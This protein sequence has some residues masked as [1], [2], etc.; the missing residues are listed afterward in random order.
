MLAWARPTVSEN[1]GFFLRGYYKQVDPTG[2]RNDGVCGLVR[3]ICGW[4]AD[5]WGFGPPLSGLGI[6]C[7]WFPKAAPWAG[8][9]R[10]LWGWETEGQM[11]GSRM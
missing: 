4:P 6:V 10:P 8:I 3:G 2:L 9:E 5:I 1:E 7:G 11:R